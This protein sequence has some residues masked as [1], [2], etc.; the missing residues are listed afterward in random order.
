MDSSL[1]GV[2]AEFSGLSIHRIDG[3]NDS[4][5]TE[6]SPPEIGIMPSQ[7]SVMASESRFL[8]L[9]AEIR[10]AI[11]RSCT[12]WQDPDRENCRWDVSQINPNI[13]GGAMI[14]LMKAYPELLHELHNLETLV[15]RGYGVELITPSGS[16]TVQ[17]AITSVKH[18]LS[19]KT[20]LSLHLA[21]D[22][23]TWERHSVMHLLGEL[24]HTHH[25]MKVTL[26]IDLVTWGDLYTDFLIAEQVIRKRGGRLNFA[27]RQEKRCCTLWRGT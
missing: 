22:I 8:R 10:L 6:S 7:T 12:T 19:H 21:F 4:P 3:R 11:Y 1:A 2:T 25:T 13:D 5:Y 18:L 9:P 23:R 24:T 27:N 16:V 20:E 17:P 26:H 15:F 14:A